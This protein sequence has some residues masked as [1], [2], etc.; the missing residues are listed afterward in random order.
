M[1]TAGAGA[2]VSPGT[3]STG[4]VSTGAVSTGVVA[5]L[6]TVAPLDDELELELESS[7]QA[8]K[9]M[10]AAQP[11]LISVRGVDFNTRP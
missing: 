11:R 4:T 5:S 8:L 2:T 10:T 1:S 9:A 7:L 6:V 3:V